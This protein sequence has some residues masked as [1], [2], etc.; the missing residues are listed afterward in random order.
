MTVRWALALCVVVTMQACAQQG[1]SAPTSAPALFSKQHW[2]IASATC[3]IGCSEQTRAFLKGQVGGSVELGTTLLAV[4]FDDRCE[5]SLRYVT[6]TM[7]TAAL[8]AEVNQGVPPSHRQMTPAD[9]KLDPQGT[10][11]TAV[12][13]CRRGSGETTQQRLLSVEPDRVLVLFEEQSVI[14]LR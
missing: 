7:P 2:T 6:R 12:A 8:V 14:E 3:P 5:G 9:L 13:L 10:A 11:T 1:A 4:P